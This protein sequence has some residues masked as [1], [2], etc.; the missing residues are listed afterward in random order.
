M[1]HHYVRLQFRCGFAA[2]TR[3]RPEWAKSSKNS[4]TIN[5]AAVAGAPYKTSTYLRL[6]RTWKD[7]DVIDVSFPMSL[8]TDPLNDK[9]AWYGCKAMQCNVL[10]L[11]VN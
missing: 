10:K 3:C 9:H 6:D 1:N 8:W 7:G 11:E 5:G 4:V 2:H